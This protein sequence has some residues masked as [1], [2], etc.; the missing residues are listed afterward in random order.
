MNTKGAKGYTPRHGAGAKRHSS[1]QLQQ[2]ADDASD[3]DNAPSS[4]SIVD[5]NTNHNQN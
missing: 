1:S 2:Q 4:L 5:A 3:V